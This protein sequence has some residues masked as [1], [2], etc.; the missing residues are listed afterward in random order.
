MVRAGP[1]LNASNASKTYRPP[2]SLPGITNPLAAHTTSQQ[3][4][5]LFVLHIGTMGKL[6]KFDWSKY[7]LD[8]LQKL[9][10]MEK[11]QLMWKNIAADDD[12]SCVLCLFLLIAFSVPGSPNI[13]FNMPKMSLLFHIPLIPGSSSYHTRND[14]TNTASS[15]SSCPSSKRA[16]A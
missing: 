10:P 15:A 14:H 16:C 1:R 12:V 8:S 9:S 6:P 4:L 3:F 11:A 5:Q 7:D 13:I 2:F